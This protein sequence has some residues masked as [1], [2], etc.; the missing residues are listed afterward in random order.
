VELKDDTVDYFCLLDV[1][2]SMDGVPLAE[3]KSAL[4]DQFSLMDDTDRL[5]VIT[6]DTQ[7]YFKLKPRP[8]E[9]LRRQNEI[10]ALM[11]RIFAKGMTAV[12]DAIWMAADQVRYKR[13]Q[14]MILVLTDGMDNSSR[15]TY[16][17]ARAKVAELE[18]AT[19]SII[20]VGSTPNREYAEIVTRPEQYHL[21]GVNDI[22]LTMLTVFRRVYKNQRRNR[23]RQ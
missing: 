14:V 16:A 18:N 5:S 21:I 2:S 3:A 6:F 8:V 20:H 15:H 11:D 23:G 10:P 1:S 17:E 22:E 7:A 19:L 4:R 13:R 12:W 9:Q